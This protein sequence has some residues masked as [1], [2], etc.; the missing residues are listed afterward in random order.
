MKLTQQA[1]E[2]QLSR[3]MFLLAGIQATAGFALVGR[4]YYLQFV[5]SEEYRTL[6]E[7]NRIKIQLIS[8]ARGDILDRGGAPLAENETNYRVIIEREHREQAK[9]SFAELTKIIELDAPAQVA[10]EKA[11]G[12][13]LDRKPLMIKEHLSWPEVARLEYHMPE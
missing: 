10:M 7:G 13:R 6:A 12:N 9:T 2:K 11:L 3:R 1:Q 8:P 4:L 5:K